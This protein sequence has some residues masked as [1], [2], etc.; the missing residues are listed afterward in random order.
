MLTSSGRRQRDA[1]A[2]IPASGVLK[3]ASSP[4]IGRPRSFAPGHHRVRRPCQDCP[5]SPGRPRLSAAV[6]RRSRAG[7][8]SRPRRPWTAEIVPLAIARWSWRWIKKSSVRGR[9]RNLEREFG[10]GRRIAAFP[11]GPGAGAPIART[12]NDSAPSPAF[13]NFSVTG[14]LSPCDQQGGET[15]DHQVKSARS[16]LH[17]AARFDRKDRL[18]PGASS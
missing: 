2:E 1:E 7:S 13:S 10:K 16:E 5:M 12:S 11:R 18:R 15:D 17:D 6:L 8:R 9:R 14:T 3:Q 4:T